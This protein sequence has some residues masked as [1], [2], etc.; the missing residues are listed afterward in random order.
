MLQVGFC[1][2]LQPSVVQRVLV[3]QRATYLGKSFALARLYPTG[4]FRKFLVWDRLIAPRA[5]LAR[6]VQVRKQVF[7]R[8]MRR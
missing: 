4:D 1:F 7:P 5:T 3:A 2:C 8:L 6:N